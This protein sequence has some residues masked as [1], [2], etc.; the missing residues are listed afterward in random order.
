LLSLTALPLTPGFLGRIGL[1]VIL[2]ESGQWLL[3]I[4]AS[5]TTLLVLAPLWDTGFALRGAESQEPNRSELAGLFLFVLAFAALSLAP[6]LIAH[7]LAPSLG[8]SAEGVLD[9]VIRTN[10]LIGVLAGIVLAVLPVLGSYGLRNAAHRLHPRSGS[11]IARLERLLDLEW[12]ERLLTGVGYQ[13]G[14]I[15]RSASTIEEENPTV[16]ILLAG[17]W[18][19]VFVSVLR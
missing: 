4:V 9:R 19:A 2:A 12:L 11:T 3:L 13:M 8:D 14:A 17:L 5:V 18:V 16:W 6:M 7:A 10:D 1:Y 15:A